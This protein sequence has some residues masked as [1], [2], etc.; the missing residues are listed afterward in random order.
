MQTQ[1]MCDTTDTRHQRRRLLH[2]CMQQCD[3]VSDGLSCSAVI[4]VIP[5]TDHGGE[6][7]NYP[8]RY[9]RV[10]CAAYSQQVYMC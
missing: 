7:S 9:T 3:T 10:I 8:A 6:V 5:A 2:A 4:T 1:G